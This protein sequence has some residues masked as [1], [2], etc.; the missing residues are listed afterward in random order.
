VT[1]RT[2]FL[3]VTALVE[4]ATGA[5][6]LA[7]PA[8]VLAALLGVPSPAVETLAVARILGTAL[9]AVGVT[10][11]LARDE[12]AADARAVLAGALVYDVLVTLVLAYGGVSLGM[13]GPALWP[14]VTLHTLLAAW[15]VVVLYQA[16]R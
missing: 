7:A 2:A 14:T 5:A 4:I 13:A 3:L 11:A 10:C 16:R 6:L 1:N 12:A 9:L 15:A 8:L